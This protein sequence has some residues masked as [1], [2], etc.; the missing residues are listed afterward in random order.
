MIRVT[1]KSGGR[2]TDPSS[3]S[4]P[5]APSEGSR[6]GFSRA[7]AVLIAGAY[8]MENL[9]AT[10]IAPAA[11]AIA[12]SLGVEAVQINVAMTAYLL[13]VAVLIPASGWLSDRYGARGI[14]SLAIAV[15]TVASVGCAIAPTLSALTVAR[16]FQGIGGAMM[17]PVGRLIVLRSTAKSEL[18]K[19]IAYLTWP[20]LVAPVLAPPLGGLISTYTCLLYTSDAADEG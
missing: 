11:P 6:P 20:A 16:V 17:V 18:I 2:V 12:E 19:A 4:S 14:F 7:L 5:A 15:F 10:I 9:D 13:T 3:A 1:S 8:F